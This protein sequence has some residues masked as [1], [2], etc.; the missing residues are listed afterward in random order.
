MLEEL[1]L[2]NDE[3]ITKLDKIDK[4]KT[5]DIRSCINALDVNNEQHKYFL[6]S[7]ESSFSFGELVLRYYGFLQSLFVSIDSLYA[8][9]Y[10][11]TNSKSFININQNKNLRDLKYIR[12]D[13]VGHPT[14]RVYDTDKAYC[15]LKKESVTSKSL[16]YDIYFKNI[17]KEKTI[18]FLD[19]LEN[20]YD[21]ANTLVA[22]F[23]ELSRSTH[24]SS[25]ILVAA[26]NLY[27]EFSH[28]RDFNN[29]L[30]TLKDVY[31]KEYCSFCKNH[32]RLM[33]RIGIIEEIQK[34]KVSSSKISGL[35]NYAISYEVSKIYELALKIDNKK[36]IKIT[37][38][39]KTPKALVSFYKMI[40]SSG[41]LEQNTKYLN[42]LDHPLF[43]D[44]FD[45]IYNYAKRHENIHVVE[46]LEYFYSFAVA[47]NGTM[48]YA[49]GILLRRYK[50]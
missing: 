21:E 44:N 14:N 37:I 27:L 18:S 11:T 12:N 24:T 45:K 36:R 38:H 22:S 23:I 2:K 4:N 25:K 1:I 29:Q 9:A 28:G 6:S 42:E 33:W 10:Y 50:K 35:L 15:I 47:D 5:P 34:Q 13:I 20:Y 30:N 8:L 26:K 16:S 43:K 49:I 31:N 19:L 40:R 32:H 17:R 39:G 48:V 46:L 7:I 3:L 41:V